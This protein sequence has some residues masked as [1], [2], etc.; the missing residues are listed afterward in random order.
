[1]YK[2]GF[3]DP[4]SKN[5]IFIPNGGDHLVEI[6]TSRDNEINFFETQSARILVDPVLSPDENGLR[7]AFPLGNSNI[8][9]INPGSF[10]KPMTLSS[11]RT[12]LDDDR[13]LV[14]C[15]G[16][17]SNVVVFDL[18]D[19]ARYEF[20]LPLDIPA[21]TDCTPLNIGQVIPGVPIGGQTVAFLPCYNPYESRTA[22]TASAPIGLFTYNRQDVGPPPTGTFTYGPNI[23]LSDMPPLASRSAVTLGPLYG[24]LVS[25]I[26]QRRTSPHVYYNPETEVIAQSFGSKAPSKAAVS[27][28]L[29]EQSENGT[30]RIGQAVVSLIENDNTYAYISRSPL[31]VYMRNSVFDPATNKVYTIPW[32]YSF[33]DVIDPNNTSS[34]GTKRYQIPRYKGERAA[35]NGFGIRA[36]QYFR[37]GVLA[38]D[39]SIYCIPRDIPAILKIDLTIVGNN[40]LNP[41][42]GMKWIGDFTFARTKWNGGV[43]GNDGKIYTIPA[44]SNDILVIDTNEKNPLKQVT[45][46]VIPEAFQDPENPDEILLDEDV[47]F[48]NT[49]DKWVSGIRATNDR[50][51]FLP[52]NARFVLEINPAGL[53]PQQKVRP[54]GPDLGI[55]PKTLG[56][57]LAPNGLIYCVPTNQGETGQTRYILIIDPR[58][59]NNVKVYKKYN[60]QI[61]VEGGSVPWSD[62]I[63]ADNG[64][65]YCVPNAIQSILVITPDY[66]TEDDPDGSTYSVTTFGNLNI[67]RNGNLLPADEQSNKF[68]SVVKASN[69]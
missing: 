40:P 31:Y 54:V 61:E 55:G 2:D 66:G 48:T 46:L 69:G 30:P 29:T 53:T 37:G 44:S 27:Q 60:T 42:R 12:L 38:P 13:S 34:A 16:M 5:M 59:V 26:P 8:V 21:Y 35:F 10:L 57:S 15:P 39:G 32:R 19:N 65:M 23:T 49:G 33:I 43:L 45:T 11:S 68:S 25:W 14:F 51:Y 50:I 47:I 17:E 4:P 67:G 62:G 36:F 28:V 22:Y 56:G 52:H 6:Y 18:Q 20:P 24:G 3:Y 9:E 1:V 58:D 41:A 64:S 7:Y 63:F